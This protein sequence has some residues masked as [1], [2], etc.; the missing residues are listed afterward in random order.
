MHTARNFNH[1][2]MEKKIVSE[3]SQRDNSYTDTYS[4][5]LSQQEHKSG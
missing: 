3:Q 5:C 4:H 1:K 2:Q